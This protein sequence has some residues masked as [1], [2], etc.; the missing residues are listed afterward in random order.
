MHADARLF[1]RARLTQAGP[2][3]PGGNLN[4]IASVQRGPYRGD[5]AHHRAQRADELL[6]DLGIGEAEGDRRG[7]DHLTGRERVSGPARTGAADS[8]QQFKAKVG[9]LPPR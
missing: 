4:A 7:N 2:R 8:L 5:V 3:C 9:M 6:G 1:N